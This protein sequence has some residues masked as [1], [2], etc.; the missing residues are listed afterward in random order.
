MQSND[1]IYGILQKSW[2]FQ[3]A[4]HFV[5][6]H[7]NIGALW[8]KFQKTGNVSDLPRQSR[9]RVTTPKDDDYIRLTHLRDRLPSATVTAR[10]TVGAH[11]HHISDQIV[12][13]RL[14]ASGIRPHRPYVWPVLTARHRRAR[15]AWPRAHLLGFC[16]IHRRVEV[17]PQTI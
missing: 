9:G 1:A 5:C 16:I 8:N 7:S 15:L 12:R 4:R 2:N 11:G 13:N 14:R 10:N 3:V 6:R 17:Q